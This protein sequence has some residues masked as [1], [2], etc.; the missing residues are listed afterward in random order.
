MPNSLIFGQWMP[1]QVACVSCL[2][3]FI[4][5]SASPCFLAQDAPGL[6]DN[7]PVL[8]QEPAILQGTLGS[9]SCRVRF[10]N[11]HLDA[12]SAHCHWGVA[13]PR[14]LQ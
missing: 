6:S 2:Y 14:L 7:V 4:T 13:A 10:R 11:Q 9:F 1:L 5:L 8:A 12:G 3:V